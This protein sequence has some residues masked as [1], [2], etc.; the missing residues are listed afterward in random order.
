MFGNRNVSVS[1]VN[2]FLEIFFKRNPA[3]W[4]KCHCAT[5]E[6]KGEHWH[7]QDRDGF[8]KDVERQDLNREANHHRRFRFPDN[9][10]IAPLSLEEAPVPEPERRRIHT[11]PRTDPYEKHFEKIIKE[12]SRIPKSKRG[13]NRGGRTRAVVDPFEK[14]IVELHKKAFKT[15]FK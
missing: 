13:V 1:V 12:A 10:Y 14:K 8:I 7:V 9:V 4:L 6:V 5:C 11:N 3:Y 15:V 2:T